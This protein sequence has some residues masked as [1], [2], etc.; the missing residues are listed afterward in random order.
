MERPNK[1]VARSLRIS[2]NSNTDD[3][4]SIAIRQSAL[5]IAVVSV[6]D[7]AGRQ[8]TAMT[9]SGTTPANDTRDMALPRKHRLSAVP[10]SMLSEQNEVLYKTFPSRWIAALAN[11]FTSEAL[12]WLH[13]MRASRHMFSEKINPW[14][15]AAKMLAPTI[16]RSHGE[17]RP[18]NYLPWRLGSVQSVTGADHTAPYRR[19]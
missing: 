13:P 14:M 9:W 5:F 15:A 1:S 17:K 4:K 10:R 16:E 7:C 3:A 8:E 19:Q 11:P 12:K 2:S 18:F 6:T